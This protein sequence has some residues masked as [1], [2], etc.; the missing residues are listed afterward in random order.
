MKTAVGGRWPPHLRPLAPNG[1]IHGPQPPDPVVPKPSNTQTGAPRR[2][3][4]PTGPQKWCNPPDAFG[5]LNVKKREWLPPRGNDRV[6]V[7]K[8]RAAVWQNAICVY[9]RTA[10]NL[11]QYGEDGDKMMTQEQLAALDPRPDTQK[12]WNARL[13]G[14]ANLTTADIA[15]LMRILPDALPPEHEV[16]MFLD[17]AEKRISAPDWWEWPD[18]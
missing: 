15:T 5:Q 6:E 2:T 3:K 18:T 11:A 7:A 8:F 12:R 1:K 4:Q 13:C 14:R 17:V 16:Q 10:K 9:V